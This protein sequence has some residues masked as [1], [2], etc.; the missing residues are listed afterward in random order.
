MSKVV[1]TPGQGLWH[2]AAAA[3]PAGASAAD[4]K[5]AASA[6]ARANQLSPEARLQ[7]GQTLT[8]PDSL[9]RASTPGAGVSVA[10]LAD[11][12]QGRHPGLWMNAEV[13]K[14][15]AARPGKTSKA[16]AK[17]AP[18]VQL[19]PKFSVPARTPIGPVSLPAVA[20][21]PLTGQ[22]ERF[23][24]M[25]TWID[26]AAHVTTEAT[27][28]KLDAGQFQAVHAALG[29]RSQVGFDPAR[30]YRLTDF[31]P[32]TIQALV[33]V[34]LEI[35]PP[36]PV[37][38]A[39]HI[40]EL[41]SQGQEKSIGLTSNCHGAAWEAMRAYQAPQATLDVF[42][43]EMITMDGLVHDEARFAR[44]AELSAAEVGQLTKL[45]LR[46]GD[47][48]QFYDTNEWARMTMLLHSAVY[49]GG[50]LFFEKPN[51][52]GHEVSNPDTYLEQEETPYR[53]ATLENMVKPVSTAVDGKIR[54]EVLRAQAPLA[55]G[56]EAF[57]TG[58]EADY[59]KLAAKKGT[60]LGVEL[61]SE[62]EQ[63]MG[64]NLRADYASA[65]V[66]MPLVIDADGRGRLAPSA[67]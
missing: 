22:L 49:V 33:N 65:A 30:T 57:E 60:T 56:N 14:S 2:V 5:A 27:F 17:K 36:Q 55:P 53:L 26:A 3:L 41:M 59:A 61:V 58:L 28:G 15:G 32:P 6:I 24:G 64:G 40:G 16:A 63:G 25:K 62:F 39:A 45:D 43:G 46:P 13:P 11:K 19:A 4:V 37:K 47:L 29:G 51:T 23:E 21:V 10:A 54:V 31:L 7:V 8:L 38:G 66:T 18:L 50:G 1:V 35:P 48:V 20:G 9:V 67:S 52:E 34:D 42:Y 12:P 44:V